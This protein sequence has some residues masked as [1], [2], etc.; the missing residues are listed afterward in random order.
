[1]NWP[2]GRARWFGGALVASLALNAFFIGAAATDVLRLSRQGDH[3]KGMLRFELRWLKGKL[4]PDAMAK[5]EAAVAASRPGAQAH[6]DRLR[7]LRTELAE[8]AAAPQPDR[9]LID[10]KL[11]EIR[12][13]LTAMVGDAQA[14]TMDSLLALPAEARDQL[15]AK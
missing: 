15:A 11:A 9:A 10:A 3:D 2:T 6:I 4:P 1:M 7:D 8:L 14:V 5:V 13:E 12:V